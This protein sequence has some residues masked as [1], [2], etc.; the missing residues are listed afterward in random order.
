MNDPAVTLIVSDLHLGGGPA[1]PGDDHVHDKDQFARFIREQACTPEGRQGG[2]ELLVNGDFLEFAQ[3]NTEAFELVS[4]TCWCNERQSLRKLDTILA[5][6]PTIFEALRQFQQAGNLVT[7]SAGNHDVD[8]FWPAVQQR[9]RELIG[10]ALRIETGREWTER[11]D[12]KLQVGHGHMSD[13]ANRFQH[14]S[15]PIVTDAHGVECLEMCP[16]TLFMVKFVNPLEARYPFADNLQPV[17]KLASVLLSDDRSGFAAVGWM[18]LKMFGTTDLST[19]GD[20]SGRPDA[21][22]YG[23]TMLRRL[24]RERALT[25]N[26]ASMLHECGGAESSASL[27]LGNMNET[28]LAQAML[29]LLGRIDTARWQAMF[30]PPDAA[31]LSTGHDDVTLSAIIRAGFVDGKEDLRKAAQQ[32]AKAT[33]AQVLVMGH[34]HQPDE[35]VLAEGAR[36]HNPGSWTRY[37]EIEPGQR[38]TLAQLERE[39]LYPFQLN[40]TRVERLPEGRLRSETLCVDRG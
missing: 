9:L 17:S 27:S 30:A 4:E 28:Q 21:Q 13:I 25:D 8:L 35:Q 14:W 1:D 36:Y 11:H 34:T 40:A 3:T 6:H 32:R 20:T 10:P 12:G 26:L 37:M 7:L 23:L 5:G 16:G 33:G 22:P 39:D 19:L 38:V 2:I 15:R 29:F 31:T 18:F 24:K